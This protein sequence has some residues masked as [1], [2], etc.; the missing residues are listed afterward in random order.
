MLDPNVVGFDYFSMQCWGAI[1]L[2]PCQNR[3][4]SKINRKKVSFL[5]KNYIIK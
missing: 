4:F 2:T 1:S 5:I 3:D